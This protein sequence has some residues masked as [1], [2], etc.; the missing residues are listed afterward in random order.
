MIFSVRTLTTAGLTAFAT[1]V[2]LLGTIS[3]GD[4]FEAEVCM[5]RSRPVAN[6]IPT[7][8][9]M[10]AMAATVIRRVLVFAGLVEFIYTSPSN[11]SHWWS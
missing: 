9:E 7:S 10:N 3:D 4:G 2:K 8:M 1:S 11:I 6:T 5:V